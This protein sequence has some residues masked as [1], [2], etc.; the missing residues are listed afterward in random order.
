MTCGLALHELE[1]LLT[2]DI[3]SAETLRGIQRRMILYFNRTISS[4]FLH[5]FI[6]AGLFLNLQVT[7]FMIH[8]AVMLRVIN[9]VKMDWLS[10][11]SIMVTVLTT[12]LFDP[13]QLYVTLRSWC[14]VRS[15]TR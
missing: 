9:N 12:L 8:R 3:D 7:Q 15:A 14:R 2:A 4:I 5:T 13:Y 6:R 1:T 10:L 11:V